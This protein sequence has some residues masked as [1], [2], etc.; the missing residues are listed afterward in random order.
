MNI[1]TRRENTERWKTH[2]EKR[3]DSGAELRGRERFHSFEDLAG[4]V[5]EIHKWDNDTAKTIERIYADGPQATA[6][7]FAS[8]VCP[9]I[10]DVD[11]ENLSWSE[12]RDSLQRVID[13]RTSDLANLIQGTR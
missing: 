12:V 9:P 1:P 6:A 11:F 7:Q 10:P 4:W 3:I 5:D 8:E 2:L 13:R